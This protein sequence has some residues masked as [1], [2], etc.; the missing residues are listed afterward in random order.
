MEDQPYNQNWPV[1]IQE[2]KPS[3]KVFAKLPRTPIYIVLDNIRSAHNVGAIFRTADS[4]RAAKV[5]IC[6]LTPKPPHPHIKK[7][8]L[9]AYEFVP[10]QACASTL[11]AITSLQAK[12]VKV[13]AIEQTSQSQLYTDKIIDFP[14]AFVFGHELGGV[15]AEVLNQVDEVLQ[16]PMLGMAVSLNVATAVGVVSYWALNQYHAQSVG[17]MP[18]NMLR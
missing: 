4:V 6:G 5:Y 15:A 13:Y 18:P 17:S 16:L 3:P 10:W 1:Q 11:K 9:R 12:E 7:T 2:Q 14:A 8:A